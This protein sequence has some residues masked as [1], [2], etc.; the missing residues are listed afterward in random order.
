MHWVMDIFRLNELEDGE[1]G[2]IILRR[3]YRSIWS[4]MTSAELWRCGGAILLL[5]QLLTSEI[6]RARVL[7]FEGLDD[8]IGLRTGTQA[9]SSTLTSLADECQ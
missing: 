6:H 2:I 1:S 3:I 5:L 4:N 8:S 9:R 7:Y